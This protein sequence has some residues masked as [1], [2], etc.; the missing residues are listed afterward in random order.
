VFLDGYLDSYLDGYLD[1]YFILGMFN[2]AERA[3]TA[4]RVSKVR[5]FIIKISSLIKNKR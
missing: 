1:G 5:I 4:N 2:L 3:R